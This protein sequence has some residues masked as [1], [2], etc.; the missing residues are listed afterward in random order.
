VAANV[1]ARRNLK[2]HWTVEKDRLQH[3]GLNESIN[4]ISKRKSIEALNFGAVFF[5]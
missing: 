3:D 1:F 5:I 2:V 4:F